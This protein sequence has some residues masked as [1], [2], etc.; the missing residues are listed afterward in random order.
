MWVA[1]GSYI[2]KV[3]HLYHE[4][5]R[6]GSHFG[7]FNSIMCLSMLIGG[8]IAAAMLS[9]LSHTLYFI[10][11]ASIAFVGVIY[12]IFFITDLTTLEGF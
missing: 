9:R 2:H 7:V 3:L 11:T 5:K 6:G 12:G 4:S 1:V 10:V 8:L